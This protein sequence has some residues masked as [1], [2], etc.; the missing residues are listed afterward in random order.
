MI[1]AV[2]V[3]FIFEGKNNIFYVANYLFVIKIKVIGAKY[4]HWM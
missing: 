2:N 3:C 4:Q 1:L